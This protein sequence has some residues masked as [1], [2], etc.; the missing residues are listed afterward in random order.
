MLILY[1][2]LTF[3][4][5]Y[6]LDFF[7]GNLV[8]MAIFSFQIGYIVKEAVETIIATIKNKL[9]KKKAINE[10]TA[11][12]LE[13]FRNLIKE[14]GFAVLGY[15]YYENNKTIDVNL[16]AA[17]TLKS[18]LINKKVEIKDKKI[19][20]LI[21]TNKLAEEEQLIL[22][23]YKHLDSD[24]FKNDFYWLLY[25]K[26]NKEPFKKSFSKK[27]MNNMKATDV[28]V[29]MVYL[30][31]YGYFLADEE[32][33]LYGFLSFTLLWLTIAVKA[34]KEYLFTKKLLINSKYSNE[35]ISKLNGL[36]NYI[37]EFGNFDKK[38]LDEIAFYD[39]YMLFAIMLDTSPKLKQELLE[40]YDN[41]FKSFF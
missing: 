8:S 27:Y 24:S 5:F 39:E 29:I 21:L 7:G 38:K 25:K 40:E 33:I 41:I 20:S 18:L 37:N 2:V 23:K 16:L 6:F 22:E 9:D 3:I 32:Q 28:L 31:G 12:E 34:F 4:V 10:E 15:C 11:V 36:K 35:I 1:F 17:L 26:V 13:Y 14:H 19:K 30:C